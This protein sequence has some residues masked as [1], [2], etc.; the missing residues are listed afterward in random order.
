MH[1]GSNSPIVSLLDMS[2]NRAIIA[3]NTRSEISDMERLPWRL[4]LTKDGTASGAEKQ[5]LVFLGLCSFVFAQ[6]TALQLRE[7]YIH[8][9]L[10]R[11]RTGGAEIGWRPAPEKNVEAMPC[12]GKKI[13]QRIA[14][15]TWDV[16]HERALSPA[17]LFGGKA[18]VG[19]LIGLLERICLHV[20]SSRA[21][22][23]CLCDCSVLAFLCFWESIK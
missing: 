3:R 20:C 6:P 7:P 2:R 23:M 19:A 13:A 14:S 16:A 21:F 8:N 4:V 11:K 9:W 15:R 1:D 10:A 12:W 17:D 5:L 22:F 18:P